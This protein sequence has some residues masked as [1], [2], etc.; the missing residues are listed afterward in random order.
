MDLAEL[1]AALAAD[2][3]VA[4]L[5]DDDLITHEATLTAAVEDVDLANPSAEDLATLTAID[6]ATTAV[7]AEATTRAT[8]AAERATQAAELVARIRPADPDPVEATDE[9]AAGDEAEATD[10]V[11]ATE[12][13]TPATAP[14]T[15]PTAEA[16]APAPVA[17]VPDA[18][19]P[20][21]VETPAP[22]PTAEVPVPIAAAA[23][24]APTGRAGAYDVSPVPSLGRA[25]RRAGAQH[26]PAARKTSNTV[27]T[28]SADVAGYAGGQ[29]ITAEQ[30]DEAI[31]EKMASLPT[32]PGQ[33][34]HRLPVATIRT[35]FDE[36][37]VLSRSDAAENG[38]KLAAVTASGG[39]CA[40][41][42]V[43]YS[44]NVLGS[45]DRPLAMGLPQFQGSRGGVRFMQ[46]PKIGD[47]ASGASV[48]TQTTDTTP[49][50]STKPCVAITCGDEVV[51]RTEALPVC[52]TIG[53]WIA[54]NYDERVQGFRSLLGVEAA[55]FAE[56][57]H[58]TT[59]GAGSMHMPKTHVLGAARDVL[60]RLI[61]Q[62]AQAEDQYRMADNA[63]YDLFAPRFLGDMMRVD[64]MRELPG[65]T[66]ER[67]RTA[68]AEINAMFAAAGATVNWLMDGESGASFPAAANNVATRWPTSVRCYLFP[69]GS[70]KH[71]DD[72]MLN[73]SVSG[74]YHDSVLNKTNDA[75]IWWETFENVYFQGTWSRTLDLELCP[76]GATS[77][78]T[79]VGC[80]SGS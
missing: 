23:V 11:P 71:L 24:P 43:D 35:N 19:A 60:A 68:D 10:E 56:S 59:I 64:L 78:T 65:S 14:A 42:A 72:G 36:D 66:A 47:F 33:G 67:L 51:V 54:R 53:N 69:T 6:T 70:W 61:Q 62:I 38:R 1:L 74:P 37:R 17:A 25:Q 8:A 34:L 29:H 73:L 32:Q 31:A 63:S 27:I 5:S 40:P 50:G 18:P 57:R 15:A 9:G 13:E 41:V 76:S 26:R 55:R 2:G 80:L 30:L 46:P 12:A 21:P 3:A 22:A 58:L 52:G 49:G 77:A 79:A 75:Q 28:A 44:V 39:P 45:A 7:R 4:G 20:A 48:W 16:P